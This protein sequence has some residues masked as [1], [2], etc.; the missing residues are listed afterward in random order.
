MS[1]SLT[2]CHSSP[3]R[4]LFKKKNYPYKWRHHVSSFFK[5]GTTPTRSLLLLLLLLLLKTPAC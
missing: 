3:L 4:T 1:D 2:L 5:K